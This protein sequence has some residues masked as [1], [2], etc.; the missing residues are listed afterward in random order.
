MWDA[1]DVKFGFVQDFDAPPDEIL[2]VFTDAAF[3]NGI[4]NLTATSV[5]T[6]LDV[7]RRGDRVT[8]ELRYRLVVDLPSEATRFID[9]SNVSWV[10][11]SDWDLRTASSQTMFLPDQA[12]R[13]MTAS[14]TTRLIPSGRGARRD[15]DGDLR[16]RIPLLGSRIERAIIGGISDH[17]EEEVAAVDKFLA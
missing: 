6:V 16:V 13:L 15:V 11:S 14:A 2:A 3:W 10:E 17:L 4:E 1:E 9:T 7:R 5:P 8:V 12:G